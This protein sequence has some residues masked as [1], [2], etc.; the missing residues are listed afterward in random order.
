MGPVEEGFGRVSAAKVGE[1]IIKK[2]SMKGSDLL[3]ES[4]PAK[5]GGGNG[6]GYLD[7]SE[8]RPDRGSGTNRAQIA[9]GERSKGDERCRFSIIDHMRQK[10]RM[11]SMAYV[12]HRINRNVVS[13]LIAPSATIQTSEQ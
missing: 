10:H 4:S 1:A 11:I 2:S 12:L 3:V 8:Q 6:V 9:P 7:I 13:S 5:M